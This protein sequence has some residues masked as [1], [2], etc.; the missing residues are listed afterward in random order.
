MTETFFNYLIIISMRSLIIMTSYLFLGGILV[1]SC[2]SEKAFNEYA[3]RIEASEKQ[4]ATVQEQITAITGS[5]K[6]LENTDSQLKSYIV[7]LQ[8]TATEL[9]NA[10]ELNSQEIVAVEEELAGEILKLSQDLSDTEKEFSNQIVLAK[11]E[12]LEALNE[13]EADLKAKLE[14]INRTLEDL[15]AK[16]AELESIITSLKEYVD[17]ELKSTKDWTSAT[18]ATIEKYNMTVKEVADIKAEIEAIKKQ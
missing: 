16:D 11:L 14:T 4:I 1:V 6:N 3:S 15:Q 5:L 2:V 17:K 10:I 9:Q 12:Q 8:A 7:S 13:L 18:F